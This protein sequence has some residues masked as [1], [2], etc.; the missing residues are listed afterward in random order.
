MKDKGNMEEVFQRGEEISEDALLTVYKAKINLD[1]FDYGKL[2]AFTQVSGLTLQLRAEAAEKFAEKLSAKNLDNGT[3]K[4]IL[5]AQNVKLPESDA[6]LVIAKDMLDHNFY[7]SNKDQYLYLSHPNLVDIY[8][9]ET[10]NGL[11]YAALENLQ[12]AL[13]EE[14]L[15]KNFGEKETLNAIIQISRGVACLHSSDLKHGDIRPENVFALMQPDDTCQIKLLTTG[16]I[17]DVKK[18]LAQGGGSEMQ[19]PFAF[20]APEKLLDDQTTFTGDI[21]SLGAMLYYYSTSETPWKL[22]GTLFEIIEDVKKGVDPFA[23]GKLEELPAP[24][25]A[26]IKK[27][28]ATNPTERY[29]SV[30]E[31]I[32]N[33]EACRD[34]NMPAVLNNPTINEDDSKVDTENTPDLSPEN[35]DE[36]QEENKTEDIAENKEPEVSLYAK[37]TE[38][39]E[40]PV[41]QSQSDLFSKTAPTDIN[42]MAAGIES[43]SQ[44]IWAKIGVAVFV[45]IIAGVGTYLFTGSEDEITS[46]EP[47]Q[48][49]IK[50]T[51][52]SAT[53]SKDDNK[54]YLQAIDAANRAMLNKDY[55]ASITSLKKALSLKDTE[56]AKGL[57]VAAEKKLEL[58]TKHDATILKAEKLLAENNFEAAEKAAMEAMSIT[59]YAADPASANILSNSRKAK[60]EKSVTEGN[61]HLENEKWQEAELAFAWALSVP[62]YEDDARALGGREKAQEAMAII[63]AEAAAKETRAKELQSQYDAAIVS[64][65]QMLAQKR[66]TEAAAAFTMALQVEGYS[67]DKAAL[68]GKKNALDNKEKEELAAK[69]AKEKELSD[70]YDNLIKIGQEN[71][72]IHNWEDAERSFS[73]ALEVEGFSGSVEAAEGRRKAMEG[74]VKSAKRAQYDAILEQGFKLINAENYEEAEKKFRSA[75]EIKGFEKGE[76]ARQGILFAS[77]LRRTNQNRKQYAI[78]IKNG[79]ELLVEMKPLD[80]AREFGRAIIASPNNVEPHLLRANAYLEAGEAKKAVGSFEQAL[81]IDPQLQVAKFGKATAQVQAGDYTGAI[82]SYLVLVK[83]G[84][85][86]TQGQAECELGLI[87]FDD[88]NRKKNFQTDNKEAL[89]YFTTAASKDNPAAL[90]NL[91]VCY[92]E[93]NGTRKNH[94]EGIKLLE[95]AALFESPEGMFNLGLAYYKGIGVDRDYKKAAGYFHSAAEAGFPR[96]WGRLADLH[97]RGRGVEKDKNKSKEYAARNNGEYDRNNDFAFTTSTTNFK[98]SDINAES[99]AS[100]SKELK[101]QFNGIIGM[102]RKLE[103]QGDLKAAARVYSMA[104]LIEGYRDNKEALSALTAVNDKIS[105]QRNS[106]TSAPAAPSTESLIDNL[107]S[108]PTLSEEEKK[109]KSIDTSLASLEPAKEVEGTK[110]STFKPYYDKLII[111]AKKF[112]SLKQWGLAEQAYRM[113]LAIPGNLDDGGAMEGL[114]VSLIEKRNAM[115]AGTLKFTD[116]QAVVD[117]ATVLLRQRQWP[118]AIHMYKYALSLEGHGEDKLAITGQ[119]IAEKA[120]FETA[121]NEARKKTKAIAGTHESRDTASYEL[122]LKQM[123][124]FLAQKNYDA[125]IQLGKIILGMKGFEKDS[126]ATRMLNTAMEAKLKHENSPEAMAYKRQKNKPLYDQL[127]LTG[128]LHLGNKDWDKAEKAYALALKLPGYNSDIVAKAGLEKAENK[129]EGEIKPTPEMQK[130][131]D[132]LM[133]QGQEAL[134]KKDWI[135]AEE[136]FR[137]VLQLSAYQKDPAALSALEAALKAQNKP[138]APATDESATVTDESVTELG[139]DYESAKRKAEFDALMQEGK[140]QMELMQYE[141]AEAIFREVMKIKGYEAHPVPAA[142]LAQCAALKPKQEKL[143]IPQHPEEELNPQGDMKM[144]AK[145]LLGEG[146]RLRQQRSFEKAVQTYSSGIDLDPENVAL[147]LNRG[148]TYAATGQFELALVDYNDS[149]AKKHITPEQTAYALNNIANVHYYGHK[150]YEKALKFYNKAAANGNAAAMNSLGVCYGFGKGVPKD[151]AKALQW[152][153]AAAEK[154]YANAMLNLGLLYENGWGV[155]VDNKTAFEWYLQATEKNVPRAFIRVSLM[156]QN[157]TGVEKDEAK[158]KEYKE[159]AIKRGYKKER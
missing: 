76:I 54:P 55:A 91:A 37:K 133:T 44:Q 140:R 31:F 105:A 148:D 102:G 19:R 7:E 52:D 29:F 75:L 90:N 33:L 63:A 21:Y 56:E 61:G 110:S 122:A 135:K 142:L 35:H 94:K 157:G 138:F 53:P 121:E 111:M 101:E 112:L 129:G 13:K 109:E 10:E 25:K 57:L 139:G 108:A 145:L 51:E 96:A 58:K 50:V 116:F 47:N 3:I 16:M 77:N 1:K 34:G 9:S 64:A 30:A 69:A 124:E 117:S 84:D 115:A 132:E 153:K 65:E 45:L 125:T 97:R 149:L 85:E 113:A 71:L 147:R 24:I 39:T 156:Y 43:T 46:S 72:K 86:K 2:Y 26:V 93:G 89:K 126:E 155:P 12:D 38:N 143:E 67:E 17:G 98:P 92:L 141:V 95:D 128:K 154:G 68:E 41:D 36:N 158:A 131:Y 134:D 22:K 123:Q 18:A 74:S 159:E 5:E 87:Y 99:E 27:A 23:E 4:T 8:T 66:W 59:G 42:D 100:F 146:D 82:E 144:Q 70:K 73:Q 151:Q 104:M 119:E 136:T 78:H 137:L 130:Q 83:T 20:S 107:P 49:P 120:A 114:R 103:K 152:Y 15:L 14:E 150:D 28:C 88:G 79:E 6:S 81:A 40:P 62:R 106:T 118:Q 11:T 127:I 32:T 80:A 60:F 48:S